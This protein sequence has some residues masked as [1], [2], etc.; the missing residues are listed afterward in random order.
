MEMP[1]NAGLGVALTKEGGSPSEDRSKP[2][3]ACVLL[4]EKRLNPHRMAITVVAL[5]V[6]VAFA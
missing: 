2:A 1:G 4:A 6:N 5:G 3:L